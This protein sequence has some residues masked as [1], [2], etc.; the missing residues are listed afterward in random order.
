[1]RSEPPALLPVFRSRH[2]ADL[3]TVLFLH[4]ERDHTA[5]E[6]AARV[7]VPLTTAHRELQ[8]L[9]ESGL[10][11]GRQVGRSRL[12][13]ADDRH[14]AFGALALLLL[15]TFG[16][17]VVVAEEFDVRVG[18]ESVLIYGSWAARYG[19]VAG[20]PP[21][22]VDVLVVGSVDRAAVYAAAERA[23]ARLGI[24][25]NPV[26]RSS[27]RWKDG[28]DSLVDAIRSAPYL[29]VADGGLVD[30][31]GGTTAADGTVPS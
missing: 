1:M 4:P 8:R 14:R 30:E 28:G 7:G 9:E 6:L 16:P 18:A 17:H 20:P 25:V 15:V 13:R 23:E 2:Q 12:L 5:T 11:V 29:E 27:G 21:G 31:R 22:D 19:G 26:V 3:L 24:P 10:L